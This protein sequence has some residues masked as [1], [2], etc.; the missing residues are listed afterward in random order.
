MDYEETFGF[1]PTKNEINYEIEKHGCTPEEFWQDRANPNS[2]QYLKGPV[3]G[4]MV[5]D[6]LGY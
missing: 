6:W 1:Y 4:K 2:Y 5:L 3:S